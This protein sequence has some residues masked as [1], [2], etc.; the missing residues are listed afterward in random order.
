MKYLLPILFNVIFFNIAYSAEKPTEVVGTKSVRVSKTQIALEG[1]FP[2]GM[3]PDAL[4]KVPVE[5]DASSAGTEKTEPLEEESKICTGGAPAAS[6]AAQPQTLEDRAKRRLVERRER[7]A[8][9][10]Y[11]MLE[12][13]V[14]GRRTSRR[15]QTI[16]TYKQTIPPTARTWADI[17]DAEKKCLGLYIECSE[18]L[19]RTE[20]YKQRFPVSAMPDTG[21]TYP[22]D[23]DGPAA[24]CFGAYLD[25]YRAYPTDDKGITVYWPSK[26]KQDGKKP[27]WYWGVTGSGD[28]FIYFGGED[29]V[30]AAKRAFKLRPRAETPSVL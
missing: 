12:R 30:D 4:S 24:E 7:R 1:L 19:S 22:I 5:G 3:T 16:S 15:R 23:E 20:A 6:A 26:P 29:I 8:I 17:S 9:N 28:T 2:D 10:S 18:V 14:R 25:Y 11:A 27:G 21:H 13:K